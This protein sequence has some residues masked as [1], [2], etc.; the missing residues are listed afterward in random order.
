MNT[1]VYCLVLESAGTRA[2]VGRLGIITFRKGYYIYVGSA[3]GPGGMARVRR[4][5]E[6][7]ELRDRDP[8]WHIDYLL[9]NGA[10]AISSAICGYS[11]IRL[12][13]NI[14]REMGGESVEGFGS[15]DCSCVSHLF[16]R[17]GDPTREILS[18][19]ERLGIP[20]MS[21]RINNIGR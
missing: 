3:L 13:C 5:L 7:A 6:L 12:E 15:S 9:L 8:R 11:P 18:L 19:F 21:K 1:G 2:R 20:V 4:H 16:Y 17:K 14:A 10:F